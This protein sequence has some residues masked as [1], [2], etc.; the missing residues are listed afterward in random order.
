MC[1][2]FWA[3]LDILHFKSRWKLEIEIKTKKKIL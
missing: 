3:A 1:G 2:E